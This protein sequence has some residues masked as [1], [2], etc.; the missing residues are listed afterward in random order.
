M[1]RGLV[2]IGLLIGSFLLLG[3]AFRSLDWW[4]ISSA[5]NAN[6]PTTAVTMFMGSCDGGPITA[7]AVLFV[8]SHVVLLWS[9]LEPR[10]IVAARQE[11]GA[12]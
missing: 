2:A 9:A 1:M 4:S 7:A 10:E 8:A 12:S 11:G 3:N 5:I 6:K